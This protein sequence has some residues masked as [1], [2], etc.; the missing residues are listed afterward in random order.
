MT[1]S[2]GN[3]LPGPRPVRKLFRYIGIAAF[4]ILLLLAI[5]FVYNFVKET[6]RNYELLTQEESGSPL[7]ATSTTATLA[8]Q[9][10]KIETNNSPWG[11]AAQAKI[12]LVEFGDFQCPYCLQ[13]FYHG[14]AIDWLSIPILLRSFGAISPLANC[15]PKL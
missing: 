6:W 4:L 8:Q 13:T 12:V 15:T 5:L 11:G 7:S 9:R 14:S 1:E 3:N 10:A 2:S